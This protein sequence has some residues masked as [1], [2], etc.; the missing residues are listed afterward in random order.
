MAELYV[1]HRTLI[2][3]TTVILVALGLR[4]A[5][6]FRSP[7]FVTKDSLE[8]VQPGY[9]LVF[10]QGFELAQRRT[11]IYPAFIAGVMALVGQDLA[12]IAFV[13]HLLGVVTAGMVFAIGCLTAGP[14]LGFAAG[15]LFAVSS[16]QIIYEH[17]VITEPVFTFLLVG[18]VLSMIVAAQRDRWVW[19]ALAG[20]LLGLAAL[21]RPVAQVLLPL[22]PVYLWFTLRGWRRAAVGTLVVWAVVG[23]LLVPWTL[24]NQRAYGSAETTSTGRF[25]ISR[26]VKHERNFVFYDEREAPR[27]EE[28]PQR[29][30]ARKI[31]QEVTNKRPAPGQVYQRVR[32]E[33]GL[34]EPQTDA[35]LRDIALEA[36]LKNPA[37][38]LEGTVEMLGELWLGAKKDE[39]L[40]W[41]LDEHDQPRVANQWGPLATMLHAPT[42]AEIREIP[43]AE[44]LSQVFRPTWVMRP[45]ALFFIVGALGTL[46]LRSWRVASWLVLVVAAQLVASTALVGEVPRYRYPVDPFIW[47]V[48]GFGLILV[49][50]GIIAAVR[51]FTGMRLRP[52][53]TAVHGQAAEIQH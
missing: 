32:D 7:V 45:L 10:G 47:V 43:V 3:L 53:R 41:H 11:P 42:P 50:N 12:G 36:I 51:R 28:S 25:L 15:L 21:T 16:P 46:V 37:L 22:V 1:T 24:R 9:G 30:R 14:L 13:Q 5:F 35:L 49:A 18:S 39:T 40:R 23:M 26:S 29:L 34:T 38:Y 20:L 27:P 48:S 17:Y 4:L 33:L 44:R 8:Y 52:M 31:A 19:Y 6:T 2:L